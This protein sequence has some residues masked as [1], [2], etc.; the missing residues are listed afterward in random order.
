MAMPA[1]RSVSIDAR[2][3]VRRTLIAGTAGSSGSASRLL[4][5][6]EVRRVCASVRSMSSLRMSS[7]LTQLGMALPRMVGGSI[8]AV[9]VAGAPSPSGFVQAGGSAAVT[10]FTFVSLRDKM[11]EREPMRAGSKRRN[12]PPNGASRSADGGRN[13][14]HGCEPCQNLA[15]RGETRIVATTDPGSRRMLV[16]HP[17]NKA[18]DSPRCAKSSWSVY[19]SAL[20]NNG[21]PL[22]APR[23][24]KRGAL[25]RCQRLTKKHPRIARGSCG[26]A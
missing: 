6:V 7:V 20:L 1:E 9:P 21:S 12:L 8:G 24:N 2:M 11:C 23:L 14:Q 10:S 15:K 5:C 3:A 22:R 25:S 4:I 13:V 19:A 18:G 26:G 17:Y 16:R